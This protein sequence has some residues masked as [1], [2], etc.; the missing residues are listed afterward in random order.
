MIEAV[1]ERLELKHELYGQ[2]SEI[3]GED[4]VLATQ[5]LLAA[6]DG[7]RRRRRATPSG[8]WACTSST[9]RR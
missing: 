1:P 6:G 7:D 2:L 5:H 3:V 8:S 9:R 4:C